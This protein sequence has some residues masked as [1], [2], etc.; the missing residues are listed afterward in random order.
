MTPFINTQK[1]RR[2]LSRLYHASRYSLSGLRYGWQEAA[3]RLE[4]GIS[5][6][7]IPTAFW[8]G[9]TWSETAL[10]LLSLGL[11]MV[12][13]LLNTAVETV[14][15]RTGMEWHALSE[16]AK[17]LGSAA[18]LIALMVSGTIWATAIWHSLNSST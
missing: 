4:A 2:G 13:E 16:K 12:T 6:V 17:D 9:Q 15:D 7:L 1:Q 10:L 8:I 18:T 5:L 3:F 11:V 14:I